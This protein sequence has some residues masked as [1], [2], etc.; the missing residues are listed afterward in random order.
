MRAYDLDWK[1][2]LALPAMTQ[3]GEGETEVEPTRYV[4]VRGAQE[5]GRKLGKDRV[6][7]DAVYRYGNMLDSDIGVVDVCETCVRYGTLCG[8]LHC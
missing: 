8:F 3:K 7:K 5:L 2:I 4:S 6:A 1:Q